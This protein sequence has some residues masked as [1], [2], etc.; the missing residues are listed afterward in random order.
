MGEDGGVL[1]GDWAKRGEG[2]GKRRADEV[3][4]RFDESRRG[5]EEESRED[6]VGE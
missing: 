3:G 6:G 1:R 4:N 2:R 5:G